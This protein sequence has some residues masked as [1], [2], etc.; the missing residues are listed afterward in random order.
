M[1]V[2]LWIKAVGGGVCICHCT[3]T[4]NVQSPSIVETTEHQGPGDGS[5]F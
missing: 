4:I 1:K 5:A 2:A 3:Q